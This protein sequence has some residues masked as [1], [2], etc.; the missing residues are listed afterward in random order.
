ML[1]GLKPHTC[2]V[3]QK[4][5]TQR[6]TMKKHLKNVHKDKNREV[7]QLNKRVVQLSEQQEGSTTLTTGTNSKILSLIAPDVQV[8]SVLVQPSDVMIRESASVYS[9]QRQ[10][11]VPAA[12]KS[13]EMINAQ[14]N[15]V[16]VEGTH[17]TVN[18]QSV[19]SLERQ[20]QPN[21]YHSHQSFEMVPKYSLSVTD[22]II[23]NHTVSH[24][25][26][27]MASYGTDAHLNYNAGTMELSEQINAHKTT[28]SQLMEADA[29]LPKVLPPTLI[30][31]EH[32]FLANIISSSEMSTNTS[33]STV[34]N[35]YGEISSNPDLDNA[36]NPAVPSPQCDKEMV[37][38]QDHENFSN[39]IC[40]TNTIDSTT[41]INPGE[42]T[43]RQLMQQ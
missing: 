11:T 33:N 2:D 29:T 10:V 21:S 12:D 37:S 35:S 22:D 3:C 23:R 38:M 27:N 18:S 4:S 32:P 20:V 9:N 1:P 30:Q 17:S 40:T 24:S 15:Q 14:N 6:S 5:F 26:N 43:L 16:E 42:V 36:E 41:L 28:L 31:Q 19:S 13:L 8:L 39:V 25:A 34:P 7:T